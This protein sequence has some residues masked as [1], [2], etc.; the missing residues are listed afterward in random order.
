MSS[1]L[2]LLYPTPDD[3]HACRRVSTAAHACHEKYGVVLGV[4]RRVWYRNTAWT[5]GAKSY[6]QVAVS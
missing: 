5:L 3:R 1:T 6:V 2:T 4:D